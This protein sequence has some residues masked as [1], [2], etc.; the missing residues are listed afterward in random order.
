LDGTIDLIGFLDWHPS[1]VNFMLIA[2][3]H[4]ILSLNGI[5]IAF[6]GVAKAAELNHGFFL[7]RSNLHVYNLVLNVEFLVIFHLHA[8]ICVDHQ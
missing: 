5:Y 7:R 3:Q 6:E 1:Y 2:C 8:A 4:F